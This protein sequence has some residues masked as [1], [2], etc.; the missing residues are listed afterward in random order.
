MN[1]YNPNFYQSNPYIPI[2]Q[3]AQYMTQQP[4]PTSA[5]PQPQ[6]NGKMV[7]SVDVARATDVPFGGYGL[8]PK[9]DL[10]EIYIKAWNN[11]GTTNL[12]TYKPVNLP[13]AQ[14]D[15]SINVSALMEKIETLETK[16][17]AIL[18]ESRVMAD[19]LPV[20]KEQPKRKEFNISEY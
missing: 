13:V 1:Y 16:I 12:I 8:F 11:N 2:Q 18:S 15:S 7:D 14:D 4:Q 10:S 17:D 9:A 3:S 19:P 20:A 6:L 5:I